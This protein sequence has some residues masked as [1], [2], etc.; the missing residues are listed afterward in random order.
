MVIDLQ[1]APTLGE[2]IK[3][4]K[5]PKIWLCP[6][7][8]SDGRIKRNPLW[9]GIDCTPSTIPSELKDKKVRKTFNDCGT[10]CII[11]ENDEDV[12]FIDWNDSLLG[13]VGEQLSNEEC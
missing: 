12:S 2:Y 3:T 13:K 10:H 5:Y 11:W 7:L 4:H 8:V 6:S 9:D 1:N